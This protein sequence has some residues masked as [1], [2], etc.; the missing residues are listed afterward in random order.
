MQFN[1]PK[2]VRLAKITA[3]VLSTL[4]LHACGGSDDEVEAPRPPVVEPEE[5]RDQDARNF[6]VDPNKLPFAELLDGP[7]TDRWWGVHEG[8]GYRVEVPEEW[9]GMLV[10]WAHGYGGTGPEVSV[11]NPAIRAYLIKNGY[12]WA[13]SSYTKN[14]YDVRAGV[15][16]TNALALAFNKIASENGRNLQAPDKIYIVG[17]SLGGHVAAAAIDQET[18]ET[19]NNK[20]SYAGAVPMCG[21]LGDMELYNYFGASQLA[22]QKLAGMPATSWPVT[23]W[24]EILPKVSDKLFNTFPSNTTETGDKYKEIVKNL[25]GGE[26]PM[27]EEG[28]AGSMNATVWGTFGRDGTI[29]GILNKDGYD[30]RGIVY[31]MD[32]D[33]AL[34][35]EERSFNETVLKLEPHSEANRLRRDGLRW[36]PKTN[37]KI[38]IPV[39]TIHTLGD[40]YVPF[41]MEQIYKRRADQEGTSQWLVQRAIRGKAHCDFTLDE[42][43]DAFDAMVNWEQK[44]VKPEGDDV[45]DPAVVADPAYGCKFSSPSRGTCDAAS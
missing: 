18:M 38:S 23:N 24:S 15:E 6:L 31:Q 9:N 35:A 45:L 34:S 1:H 44:G 33:Q 11:S 42:Q 21:V 22:A 40:M 8:A 19:A 20:V 36:F 17:Q 26:R 5:T 25:S 4:L 29:N 39:V 41:S 43:T 16:D 2:N 10:M 37:A 12:A 3:A 14:Y 13:A 7:K 27:F 32:N 28:F 30:T